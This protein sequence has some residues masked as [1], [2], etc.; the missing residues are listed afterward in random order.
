MDNRQ[1]M[2]A[3]VID[4]EHKQVTVDEGFCMYDPI[5][6]RYNFKP[7]R[8]SNGYALYSTS[9]RATQQRFASTEKPIKG[10]LVFIPEGEVLS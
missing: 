10:K 2:V 1:K 4:G 8:G 9:Q 7:D 6:G 3:T 5:T